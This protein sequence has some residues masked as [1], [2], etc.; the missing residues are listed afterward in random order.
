MQKLLRII[1]LFL[2][3]TASSFTL[4]A[5]HNNTYLNYRYSKV[6]DTN[7]TNNYNS[8]INQDRPIFMNAKTVYIQD[9]STSFPDMNYWISLNDGYYIWE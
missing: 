9:Y 3:L 8:S 6:R 2:V 4:N 5:A 1:A 7:M